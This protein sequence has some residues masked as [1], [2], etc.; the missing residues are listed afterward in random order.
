MLIFFS[1]H[2]DIS[3]N[4]DTILTFDIQW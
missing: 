4:A 2:K 3:I 1:Q